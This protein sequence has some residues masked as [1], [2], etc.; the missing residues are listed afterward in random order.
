MSPTDSMFLSVETEQ[1]PMNIGAVALL[2]PPE[3][4]NA[5]DIREMFATALASGVAAPLWRRRPRRSLA[6]LNQW[7]WHTDADIDVDYH[8]RFDALPRPGGVAELWKLISHLHSGTLDRAYPLWG[9]HLIEGLAAGRYVV[10]AKIHHA[11]ADGVSALRIMQRSLSTDPDR[12]GM[13]APWETSGPDSGQGDTTGGPSSAAGGLVGAATEAA[14]MVPAL[15][16]TA[17][18]ALRRRG[19]PL[20]L[21]APHTPLNV[22]ISGGRCFTGRALP[23]ERLRLVAKRMDA[24]VNDVVLGVCAGALRRYLLARNALPTAPLIAM[25]PVSLRGDE[26]AGPEDQVPGNKIATLMCP[27]ATDLDDPVERLAAIRASMRDGKA[28]FAGRSRRQALAMSA[29]GA[30][31]LGL[32]MVLGPTL[33]PLR[34]P[35]VMISTLP[36]STTG[37]YWNGA[38]LDALYPLSVPVDG[39]ALNITCTSINDRIM[40]GLTGCRR[41]VRAIET[42][43]DALGPELDLL[44]DV[45][46]IPRTPQDRN[47]LTALPVN[48]RRNEWR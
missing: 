17:W 48:A 4:G 14:G 25:V 31:P 13:P 5:R 33:G 41:S 29:L 45:Y 6:S 21:G 26:P 24:T 35:N 10:Y 2:T 39:Q 38:R 27:L 36:G 40:F 34:S 28:A 43:A 9:L 32:A 23:I 3:G 20:A 46:R 8:V 7:Y 22:S 19:G 42:L 44:D 15:A 37:L 18:R 47:A 1:R 16:D 30:A 12:R 11:L